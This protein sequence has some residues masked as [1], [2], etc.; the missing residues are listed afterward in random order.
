MLQLYNYLIYLL[1]IFALLAVF[2]VVYCKVTPFDEIKL[3]REGKISAALSLGG[4]L[5]GFTLTLAASAIYHADYLWFLAW[6]AGAMAVQLLTYVILSR[7][8]PNMNQALEENNVAMGS[9]MGTVSLVVG[10]ANAACLS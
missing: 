1:T 3:I 10:V 6:A 8:L 5:L 2:A 9:L 7:V 4:A